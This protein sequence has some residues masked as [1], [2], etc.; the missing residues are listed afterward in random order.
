ML[1]AAFVWV[2]LIFYGSSVPLSIAFLVLFYSVIT[3]IDMAVFGKDAWLRGGEAF[4]ISLGILS[5]FAPT[6]VRVKTPRADRKCG[7]C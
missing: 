5:R 2:E 1:Y 7:A 4:S 3:W 6:E